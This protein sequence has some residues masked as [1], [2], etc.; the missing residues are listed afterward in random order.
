MENAEVKQI[1]P[2]MAED[3][4]RRNHNNRNLNEQQISYYAQ[5]MRAGEW[6]YDGQPIRFSKSG[7]LLDGQ[8]R[9]AAVVKSKTTQEFLVVSNIDP[10]AFKVMDTG[11]VRSAVDVF[12]I[13]GIPNHK[14]VA[15][16]TKKG[17]YVICGNNSAIILKNIQFGNKRGNAE[18]LIQSFK[19]RF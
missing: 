6:L 15:K 5:Q 13:E 12:G 18:E 4:L 14:E 3:Y 8:H 1:T 7:V 10:E 19:V 16:I 11:K 9:L 2:E 17:V